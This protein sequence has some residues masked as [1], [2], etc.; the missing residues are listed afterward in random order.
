MGSIDSIPPFLREKIKQQK[1]AETQGELPPFLKQPAA[2]PTDKKKE[3]AGSEGSG[4]GLNV[5]LLQT[6]SQ[7][8]GLRNPNEPEQAVPQTDVADPNAQVQAGEPVSPSGVALRNLNRLKN[9]SDIKL[10][11]DQKADI[12]NIVRGKPQLD[13]TKTD[14]VR[15]QTLPFEE[16]IFELQNEAQRD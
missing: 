8:A 9:L 2:V 4:T 10:S 15:E 11:D 7:F 13:V 5:P 3:E 16:K 6:P 14:P 1:L 12:T